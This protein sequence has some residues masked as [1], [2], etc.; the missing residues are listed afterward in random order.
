MKIQKV[1]NC[2]ASRQHAERFMKYAGVR[3]RHLY[4]AVFTPY[5][6]LPHIWGNCPHVVWYR[7]AHMYTRTNMNEIINILIY[8]RKFSFSNFHSVNVDSISSLAWWTL[9]SQSWC[10]FPLQ[11]SKYQF[12]LLLHKC[13]SADLNTRMKLLLVS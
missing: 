11:L 4:P 6:V 1:M 2:N 7:Q 5:C 10:R 13:E 12:W 3:T 9:E 8:I